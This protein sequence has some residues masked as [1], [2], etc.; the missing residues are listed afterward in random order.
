MQENKNDH[1]TQELL[2]Q[3]INDILRAGN[4]ARGIPFHTLN[5]ILMSWAI[6]SAEICN[7]IMQK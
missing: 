1:K 2:S 5:I 4:L 7:Y 3:L 6:G